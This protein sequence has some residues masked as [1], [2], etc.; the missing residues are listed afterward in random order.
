[1]ITRDP[2]GLNRPVVKPGHMA[3]QLRPVSTRDPQ[4]FVETCLSCQL[5]TC[6][7]ES[8]ACPLWGRSRSSAGECEGR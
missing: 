3:E 8:R 7:Q 5:P 2:F 6:S 4:E 1:M